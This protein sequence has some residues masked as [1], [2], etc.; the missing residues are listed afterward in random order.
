MFT[1]RTL[2]ELYAAERLI[3]AQNVYA[4]F[5]EANSHGFEADQARLEAQMT[6]RLCDAF[7][8]AIIELHDLGFERE[9][10]IPVVHLNQAAE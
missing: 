7:D 10:L 8:T 1:F 4:N 3:K 2:D 6:A 9:H 5:R